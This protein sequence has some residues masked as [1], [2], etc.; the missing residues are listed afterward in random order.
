MEELIKALFEERVKRG[1]YEICENGHIL[2]S[3]KYICCPLCFTEL[4]TLT[5]NDVEA[6]RKEQE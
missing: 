2:L 5:W 6:D 1:F 3:E 4:R